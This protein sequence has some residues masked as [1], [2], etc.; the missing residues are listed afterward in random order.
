MDNAVE[1]INEPK[2]N[3][4]KKV[5]GQKNVKKGSR[6]A[7]FL[8]FISILGVIAVASLLVFL[9]Q[10]VIQ[11]QSQTQLLQQTLTQD[12]QTLAS[13]QTS[14]QTLAAPQAKTSRALSEAEY[15]VELA[16]YN[17]HFQGDV[18]V[19]VNLL[20]AADQQ[21]NLTQDPTATPV[22]QILANN[23]MTLQSIPQLD[24]AGM[25]LQINAISQQ[26][27]LLPIVPDQLTKPAVTQKETI[28]SAP[29][30]VWQRGLE[31]VGHAL[32]E[33]VV[34]RHLEQPAVP[35]LPPQQ[36]VYLIQN[37]QLQLSQAQW[38]LLHQQPQ[39]YQ[40]SLQQASSWI[41]QYFVSAAGTQSVLAALVQLQKVDIKPTLPD[42]SATLQQIRDQLTQALKIDNQRQTPQ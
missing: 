9:R 20:K 5:N 7:L 1:P 28:S 23:I 34:V 41:E 17:L 19:A 8:A 39:I 27:A 13:L 36:Q 12:Q 31:S 16:N 25:I 2:V 24:L 14:V 37:I 3:E 22:R 32:R 38:A 30:R 21:L 6:F 33:V 40:Q 11:L 29:E 10:Q 18:T 26:V 4:P 42:L 15:L 35:L